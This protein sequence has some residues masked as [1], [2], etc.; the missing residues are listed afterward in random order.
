MKRICI[1]A[2]VALVALLLLATVG[3]APAIERKDDA[4][5]EAELA[6]VHRIYV[7]QLGGGQTSDQM[8]DMIIV[9]LQNS[10]LF[11]VT[12]NK[13]RADAILKGSSDDRIFTED[14]N[15]SESVGLHANAAGSASSHSTLGSG[16][17]DSHS[18]GA[19]ITENESAKIQERKHEAAAAIRLVDTEGDVIWSTTQE[20]PG[21][22]F[23]GAMAD[24]AD[25]IA[26]QLVA[27][28]KKARSHAALP[29][30]TVTEPRP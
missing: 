19:G 24:V 4:G 13:E 1:F 5:P 14:H 17:S 11:I 29:S 18:T 25:R 15:T 23:R 27:D 10:G 26:R 6:L 20:S 3:S 22:K 8:R 28:T 2:P 30:K 9:A 12:E 7:D 16:V 21:G